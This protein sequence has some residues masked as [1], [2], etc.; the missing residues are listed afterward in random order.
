MQFIRLNELYH[1]PGSMDCSYVGRL[2]INV[3][4]IECY[5][6]YHDSNTL[7]DND[8][9]K[10]RIEKYVSDDWFTEITVTIGDE[11][12][13]LL[14][15]ESVDKITRKITELTSESKSTA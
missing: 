14:V 10:E 3:K 5:R 8:P 9:E 11:T 2:V 7:E 6:D 4:N 13:V 12:E 1:Q 15:A